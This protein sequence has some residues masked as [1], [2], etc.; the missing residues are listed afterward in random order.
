MDFWT[1]WGWDCGRYPEWRRLL[2]LWLKRI[3]PVKISDL[4]MYLDPFNQTSIPHLSW[5]LRCFLIFEGLLRGWDW[6]KWH[7]YFQIAHFDV[8]TDSYSLLCLIPLYPITLCLIPV[9]MKPCYAWF[10][11][12]RFRCTWFHFCMLCPI[13]LCQVPPNPLDALVAGRNKIL[14]THLTKRAMC[15]LRF[16]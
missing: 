2:E 16:T 8:M 7:T 10:R 11:Y 9:L 4:G 13:P 3:R 12:T 14:K 1:G 6:P 15:N 5:K